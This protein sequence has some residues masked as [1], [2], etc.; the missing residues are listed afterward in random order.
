[1]RLRALTVLSAALVLS[2]ATP[3][4]APPAPRDPTVVSRLERFQS[5]AEFRRYVQR[6]TGVKQQA[7]YPTLQPGADSLP[8][9]APPPPPPPPPPPAVS[10]GPVPG[11]AE[12]VVVTGS[13]IQSNDLGSF[14]DT[15][16]TESVQRVQGE[17]TSAAETIT[18]VQTHGVDE[19]DIVK[20]IGH[21]LIVL[22]D[23][24]LFTIDIR[25]HD[26]AGLAFVDRVNVYRNAR[27]G[28]W[29][30]EM[31]V[32]RNR[33]VVT[34]YN[35]GLAASEINVFSL[36]PE[37]RLTRE[38][39]YY[40]TSN[41]YYDVENYAT[42]LVDDKLVIYSP[43][44]IRSLAYADAFQWPVVRRW[45][46][47]SE[48]HPIFAKPTQLYDARDIYKPLMQT[49]DPTVHAISTCPLG[50]P[51]AGDELNCTAVAFIG[52]SSREFY[53]S[54][55]ATYL[56]LTEQSARGV[57]GCDPAAAQRFQAGSPGVL[58]RIPFTGTPSVMGVRG[59]PRDQMGLDSTDSEFRGLLM[60]NYARCHNDQRITFKY[61]S[62]PLSAFSDTLR[63]APE[64]RYHDAPSLAGGEVEERFTENYVIYGQRQSWSSYPPHG[65]TLSSS[66]I[67]LPVANPSAA[68]TVQAPHNVLRVDR[69][70]SNA[71]LTG[72]HSD[73]GLSVSVLDLSAAPRIA[74]T[75][76]LAHRYE[77]EGRS[78]AFN[79]HVGP[80]ET[81]VMG[82]PTVYGEWQSGRW[83]FRSRA[84]DISFLS[85]EGGGRLRA[86]GEINANEHAQ[87]PSYVCEVS[88]VD[89][90]G[91]TRPIFTNGRVFA[92]MG[93]E[94]VEGSA[95]EGRISEVRRIN[96]SQRPPH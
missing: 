49:N 74:S 44:S 95:A 79:S 78:H 66:V 59:A 70:G 65:R 8:A 37:G 34:G 10:A 36:S 31:L 9:P 13:N 47:G 93:T 86:L 14:P 73:E 91:N 64:A 28:T 48:A 90:Y 80:D 26:Q 27:T 22:Q 35:Y 68:V 46:G 11:A 72:Y 50:S 23:G 33:V 32:Y 21:F 88:C 55:T 54:P 39:A 57:N 19:G 76:L 71:V 60:W 18:N 20:Q 6:V 83:W 92:L 67:A 16:V 85:L 56:W 41:D 2:C 84:S 42:R 62:A 30:D 40:M 7:H 61:F 43:L 94:L 69:L 12:S 75:E 87:D 96:L 81:G 82:L 4:A 5:E 38:G 77:S 63:A 3:G 52:P 25:P 51:A 89:W 1:M 15:N 58:Y 24:R 53:V 45:V 29:Y 17:A